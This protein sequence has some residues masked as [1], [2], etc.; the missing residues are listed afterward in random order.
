M[1][2]DAREL[3]TYQG[4]P[5]ELYLF[6]S[7]DEEWALTSCDTARQFA[8]RTFTPEAIFRTET[9]KGQENESADI[10]VSLPRE[11]AIAQ[12]Y[13]AF[14]P[15]N[16]LSLVIY[17][18]HDGDP[19]IVTNFAGR[20]TAAQFT[21][22]CELTVS[23]DEKFLK[24]KIPHALFQSQCTHVL[25]RPGCNVN[26]EAYRVTALL[27]HVNAEIIKSE[28]FRAKPDHYFDTG[29]IEFG[30]ARRMILN[31][32]GDT[33][34][35]IFPLPGLHL[36]DTLAAFPG[37]DHLYN[38]H[39]IQRYSNGGNYLGFEWIPRRNPFNGMNY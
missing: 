38:G 30:N 20:V 26:R 1:T 34:A 15:S 14:L 37:C 24:R 27:T 2:Y 28:A 23:P 19:D 12:L 39:C 32:V 25:F 21:D 8:G 29:Y 13:S 16:P 18:G 10:T 31:H 3:S 33:C 7:G 36:G 6:Q 11:H 35:L 9:A 17:R 4:D 22:D 5:F